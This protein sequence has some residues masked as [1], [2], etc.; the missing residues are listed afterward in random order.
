MAMHRCSRCFVL[1]LKF[2]LILCQLPFQRGDSSMG[3]CNMR[4]K[5]RRRRC[6]KGRRSTANSTG[7]WSYIRTASRHRQVQSTTTCSGSS[8]NLLPLNLLP[9]QLPML[10]LDGLH[11]LQLPQLSFHSLHLPQLLQLHI[12]LQL[13]T[14]NLRR[15]QLRFATLT[16]PPAAYWPSQSSLSGRGT[17]QGRGRRR[18]SSGCGGWVFVVHLLLFGCTLPVL[19]MQWQ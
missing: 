7:H 8:P 18:F 6:R 12:D 15:R 3:G 9:L 10:M 5:R 11:L 1:L 2:S 4:R 13:N 17:G 19:C 16:M 14:P